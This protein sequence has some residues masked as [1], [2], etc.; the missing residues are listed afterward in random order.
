MAEINSTNINDL[1]TDPTNGGSIGGNISL[2]ISENR[3]I[4]QQQIPSTNLSLDQ[5]TISQIVN[6]LQ[7]ASLAGATQ[8]P[9]RDISLNTNNLTQ[10]PQIQPNYIPEP[11]EKNYILD[12]DDDLN[13]YYKAEKMEN[14]LD[15][16][17]DELQGPILLAVL[18]FL[19][20]LPFLKKL[21]FKYLPF[22]CLKD[23][24]YNINGLF[25][26]CGLFGFIF[27]LLSKTVK[28]FS[29]F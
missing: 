23:G 11:K 28:H 15:S 13:N 25:L 16:L 22:C 14:S 3:N 10:D 7:Q 5:T 8:L 12:S 27:Y 9:S 1:P 2:E 17:Y 6:G 26:T 20:Q 24:N 18:Y 4:P 21:I 29:K 19:F